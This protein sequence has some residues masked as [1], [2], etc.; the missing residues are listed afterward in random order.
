M[1]IDERIEEQVRKAFSAVVGKDGDEMVAAVSELTEDDAQTALGY[2]LFVVGYIVNEAFPDGPSE[3]DLRSMAD[4][5][6]S[7]V[8]EWVN[9]GSVDSVAALLGAAGSGDTTF[10]GIT[11]DDLPGM[12]FVTGGYLLA[13]YRLK[14]QRW[15]EY[16][17][18]IWAR[19]EQTPDPR[20][21]GTTD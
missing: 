1:R 20:V 4:D 13:R 9:I 11:Q 16:L 12:A 14:D 15:W 8:S 19:A 2:A 3:S 21:G 5:I 6:V 18:E 17:N 10:D 7:G